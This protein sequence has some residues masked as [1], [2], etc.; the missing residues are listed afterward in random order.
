VSPTHRHSMA[1]NPFAEEALDAYNPFDQAAVAAEQEAEELADKLIAVG[2]NPF[3]R[4]NELAVFDPFP[5][6]SPPIAKV[7]WFVWHPCS[8]SFLQEGTAVAADGQSSVG[9]LRP[10]ECA[11]ILLTKPSSLELPEG[12]AMGYVAGANMFR[13]QDGPWQRRLGLPS[14]HLLRLVT[15]GIVPFEHATA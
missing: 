14:A 3:G 15:R 7:C 8:A 11:T 13:K 5:A 4:L 12:L 6:S 9:P 10:A 1:S 2:P